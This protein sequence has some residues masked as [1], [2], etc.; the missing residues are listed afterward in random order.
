MEELN[1]PPTKLM[2]DMTIEEVMK[3]G[4]VIK[5]FI[6]NL[7]PDSLYVFT[8]GDEFNMRCSF[9]KGFANKDLPVIYRTIANS[10]EKYLAKEETTKVLH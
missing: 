10:Q 2:K 4:E 6:D 9:S 7:V 3:V 1:K 8:I 5:Q